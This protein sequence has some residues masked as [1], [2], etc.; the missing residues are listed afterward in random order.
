MGLSGRYS[1]A[2]A[3]RVQVLHQNISPSH[4]WHC[5]HKKTPIWQNFI[6]VWILQMGNLDTKLNRYYIIITFWHIFYID[7][8]AVSA[9]EAAWY[10]E[11]ANEMPLQ[12]EEEDTEIFA[13]REFKPPPNVA[14]TYWSLISHFK[15][16]QAQ[17]NYVYHWTSL[18]LK[19]YTRPPPQEQQWREEESCLNESSGQW[20]WTKAGNYFTLSP[21]QSF[22]SHSCAK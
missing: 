12:Q 9:A 5:P 2:V 11:T 4:L 10:L 3:N 1:G 21:L 13:Q 22:Q 8:L 20:M 19:P 18:S 16:L 7:F 15:N 17:N 6:G 14:P